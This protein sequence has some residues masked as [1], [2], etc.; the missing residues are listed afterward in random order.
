MS[1]PLD[2]L[3]GAAKGFVSLALA[4]TLSK[5]RYKGENI[6]SLSSQTF[7]PGHDLSIILLN[8]IFFHATIEN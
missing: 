4:V 2:G 7:F 6:T 1:L 5:W 3:Q 8:N